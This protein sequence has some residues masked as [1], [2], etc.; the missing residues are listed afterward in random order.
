MFSRTGYTIKRRLHS[1]PI[2]VHRSVELCDSSLRSEVLLR[3]ASANSPSPC[4]T[5]Y[6]ER[7]ATTTTARLLL[8]HPERFRTCA[9]SKYR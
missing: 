2:R 5:H 6:D 7:L 9:L 4:P 3:K 8:D 1:S